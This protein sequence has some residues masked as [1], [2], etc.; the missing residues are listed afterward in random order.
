MQ[1]LHQQEFKE[2]E[3]RNVKGPLVPD[4]CLMNLEFR[5]CT[6]HYRGYRNTELR[7]MAEGEKSMPVSQGWTCYLSQSSQQQLLHTATNKCTFM[8]LLFN[9]F[10]CELKYLCSC[11]NLFF[12]WLLS[13]FLPLLLAI[14]IFLAGQAQNPFHLSFPLG[15]ETTW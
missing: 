7:I 1:S 3:K 5:I 12:I 2:L 11:H 4:A 8:F 6:Y 13:C 15:L 10:S 9:V 14:S